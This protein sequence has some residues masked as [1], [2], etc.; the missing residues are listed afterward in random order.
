[1]A[2]LYKLNRRYLR[3]RV[4]DPIPVTGIYM[5]FSP[6]TV[7][8]IHSG[9]PGHYA[10]SMQSLDQFFITINF[11]PKYR[12]FPVVAQDF[13][14]L[15]II[16]DFMAFISQQLRIGIDAGRERYARAEIIT[17]LKSFRTDPQYLNH[18]F[19][20]DTFHAIASSVQPAPVDPRSFARLPPPPT[21]G[22]SM[23]SAPTEH[24]GYSTVEDSDNYSASDNESDS[25][26][27]PASRRQ[28][29]QDNDDR[30][31]YPVNL[32]P[33]NSNRKR[34][35]DSVNIFK[36]AAPVSKSVSFADN[37]THKT[38]IDSGASTCGT[39]RRDTLKNLRPTS[40]TIVAAFGD[41]A[42][43]TEMGDLPPFQLKTVVIDQMKDTTLVSVS[44]ACQKGMVG[45]FTAVDCRFYDIASVIPYLSDISIHGKERIRGVV[46]DGLY[47]QESS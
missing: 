46:E 13:I 17:R 39:G 16:Y 34:D 36:F 14:R 5:T 30:P 10:S 28:E 18:Q 31:V 47:V 23:M 19:F 24:P 11:I 22:V 7:T 1:M 33:H 45:I 25:D 35:H 41:T 37:S 15:G 2:L 26:D 38:I 43:P 21:P 3:A 32:S 4:K 44:Q 27:G 29:I 20:H 42:Q 40:C 9:D 12:Q 8:T 6:Q